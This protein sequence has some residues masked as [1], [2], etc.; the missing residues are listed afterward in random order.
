MKKIIIT[1]FIITIAGCLSAS[2]LLIRSKAGQEKQF[3][4]VAVSSDKIFCLEGGKVVSIPFTD[5]DVPFL[6]KTAPVVMKLRKGSAEMTEKCLTGKYKGEEPMKIR[7]HRVDYLTSI[8]GGTLP[9]DTY[10]DD[11]FNVLKKQPFQIKGTIAD[12]FDWG[13][14]TINAIRRIKDNAGNMIEKELHM[15]LLNL[16]PNNYKKGDKVNLKVSHTKYRHYYLCVQNS[17]FDVAIN[18]IALIYP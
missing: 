18:D 13:G 12:I 7:S 14:V 15:T 5:L 3:N 10:S 1:S 16:P 9:N 6:E 4:V 8:G 17:N 2:D 11:E